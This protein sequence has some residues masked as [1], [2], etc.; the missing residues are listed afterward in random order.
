MQKVMRRPRRVIL[1]LGL[2]FSLGVA[3]F[4][5]TGV[6]AEDPPPPAPI[7]YAGAVTVGG[8]PAPDG[9]TLVARIVDHETEAVV[10]QG[11]KYAFLKVTVPAEYLFRPV[12]F[13]LKDYD[14]QAAEIVQSF[15]G[16]PAFVD[17]F[18]LSFLALPTLTPTP[19]ATPTP[20]P[21]STAPLTELSMSRGWNLISFPFRPADPSINSVLPLTHPA[22]AVATYDKASEL[23]QVS[24]RDSTS[25]LFTGEVQQMVATNAYFVFTDGL[26]PIKLRRPGLNAPPGVPPAIPVV[27]G[28]NLLPVRTNQNPVPG[29]PPGS[30]GISA[31]D[32]LGARRTAQGEAPWVKALLWDSSKETW[33]SVSP[34]DRVRLT[35]GAINPCTNQVLVAADVESGTEPCQAVQAGHFSNGATGEPTE[36]DGADTVLM[37]RHLPIGAGIWVWYTIDSV[38]IP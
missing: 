5:W 28:W 13:H 25:G 36:F 24:R 15:T 35:R 6:Q 23:W 11:G 14:V 9:L 31:D 17:N 2:I 16:G 33:V 34:G 19:T 1:A 26:Q 20:T 8:S 3:A 27:V 12:T 4:W 22:S 30:G 37:E 32:Y 7:V 10:T 18:D 21:T 38:I 29:S